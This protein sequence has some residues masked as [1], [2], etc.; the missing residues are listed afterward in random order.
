MS[1]LLLWVYFGSF[2]FVSFVF[3]FII[4]IVVWLVFVQDNG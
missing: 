1:P 2:L 3:V 4:I